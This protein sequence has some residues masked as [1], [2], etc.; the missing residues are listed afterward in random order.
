MHIAA[1]HDGDG[2]PF[3]DDNWSL[4]AD[5][6]C[7]GAGAEV[8]SLSPSQVSLLELETPT[9]PNPEVFCPGLRNAVMHSIEPIAEELPQHDI[10]EV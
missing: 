9:W 8:S 2:T 3:L 5:A 1:M 6:Q 10:N 4:L 7:S